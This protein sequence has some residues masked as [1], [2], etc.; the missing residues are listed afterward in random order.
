MDSRSKGGPRFPP[1]VSP[2]HVRLFLLR[3]GRLTATTAHNVRLVV[4]LT[5]ATG[6]LRCSPALAFPANI[7]LRS[8]DARTHFG[9]VWRSL[10][11]GV[12][13]LSCGRDSEVEFRTRALRTFVVRA[14]RVF[15]MARCPG[16]VRVG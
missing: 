10:L 7:V 1:I 3:A 4:L 16:C 8:N 11:G 2:I 5:E 6:S 15:E 9:G 14:A 12:V 13:L